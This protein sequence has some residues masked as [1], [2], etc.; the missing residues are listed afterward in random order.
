MK[1]LL[2]FLF[3]LTAFTSSAQVYQND[4]AYGRSIDRY[5]VLKDLGIPTFC[6]TPTVN[7]T[8]TNKAKIAYD[9]C[10][11]KFYVYDPSTETWGQVTGG[12]IVIDPGVDSITYHNNQLCQWV[13]GVSTCYFLNKFYDSTALNHDSTKIL[14]FNSGNL[15]DSVLIPTGTIHI[16]QDGAGETNIVRVE[17]STKL[18]FPTL[19]NTDDITI[20]KASDSAV[21][22]QFTHPHYTK[23]QVDS[24]KA[25][26]T[27]D[28]ITRAELI[29]T[30][31]NKVNK[32][33]VSGGTINQVLKKNSSTDYDWSWQD[34]SGIDTTSLSNRINAKQD[35]LT[36]TTTGT[37]GAATLTGSTL[38]I[39]Q[40]S[41]GGGS[42]IDSITPNLYAGLGY[43]DTKKIQLALDLARSKNQKL[44]IANNYERNSN[45]WMIDSAI[46]LNSNEYIIIRN[47]TLK[48]TD[49]ARDNIFRTANCGLGIT[50]PGLNPVTGITI[51][52]IGDVI[53]QGADNPRASG[54]VGKALTL[55]PNNTYTNSYGT[56]AGKAGRSQYGDWRNYGV[57][58]AYGSNIKISGLKLSNIA[59]YGISFS[60]CNNVYIHD[61]ILDMPGY[62]VGH[63]ERLLYN[64][65]GLDFNQ[66]INNI[67][68]E[69]I[70]GIS[71]DDNIA[72]NIVN[73]TSGTRGAGTIPALYPTGDTVS[74]GS[75]S[76]RNIYVNNVNT[77]T[78]NNIRVLVPSNFTAKN[79][80][81]TNISNTISPADFAYNTW[82]AAQYA[83]NVII[84]LST[85]TYAAVNPLGTISNFN[86]NNLKSDSIRYG[87][88]VN[89]SLSESFI[90]NVIKNSK[91]NSSFVGLW[92]ISDPV[93]LRNVTYIGATAR[94][95][96]V[97]G[98][99]NFRDTTQFSSLVKIGNTATTFSSNRAVVGNDVNAESSFSVSNAT[100]GSNSAST[101][102][103]WGATFLNTTLGEISPANTGSFGAFKKKFLIEP[104]DNFLQGHWLA[105]S[106]PDKTSGIQY[107][108]GGRNDSN[109]VMTLF[110]TGSLGFNTKGTVTDIPSALVH[111]TSE[112]KA[113]LPP[114]MTTAQRNVLSG[115]AGFGGIASVGTRVGGTGYTN[116]TYS[117]TP[118]TTVSGVGTGATANITVSGGTIT[119]IIINL[120]R[121]A[122][123]SG[124]GYK[125][126]DTLSATGLGAGT[127]FYLLVGSIST[128]VA[129]N[130]VYNTTFGSGNTFNGT[131][132]VG[133]F[134]TS[135]DSALTL[136]HGVDYIF[137]GTTSTWTLPAV[138][139][140]LVGRQNAIWI[141]NKGTGT[142]TLQSSTGSVIY[143]TSAQSS[144]TIAAG[145]AVELL[146][147]GTNFNVMFN[148]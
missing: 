105:I 28:G 19:K 68:V 66:S 143:T 125:V 53:L 106:I 69:N 115:G 74:I 34:E 140:T 100:N 144:I 142:I 43:S 132:W 147:D 98:Y 65:G 136:K 48:L 54:D 92:P 11:H 135:S 5:E 112:T 9:S 70:S 12:G 33:D 63:T 58:I 76:I 148:N 84:G 128:A 64:Q 96:D 118:L 86:I 27:A 42:A 89:T 49:S 52:G 93:I 146:P 133:D 36:L 72:F 45:L 38:N 101:I 95:T 50:N 41:G 30:A 17:D 109:N 1:K 126:G 137:T 62:A 77:R 61:I 10:G 13:S 67:T 71:A 6:G 79:F 22:L 139:S 75:D 97:G 88:L 120:A 99:R 31:N 15:V 59:A 127:G 130:Y 111:L 26:I 40:Y 23:D 107:Y 32:T 8:V 39:P 60:R 21:L 91:N 122:Q 78:L 134:I 94:V 56:D 7:S 110:P 16:I 25:T 24:I 131:N 3:I 47:A 14:H 46:L 2:T 51:E 55:T 121:G 57:I 18:H 138:S 113:F 103:V 141:K 104:S 82:S 85:G 124:S 80:S 114:R 20:S 83:S 35:A 90:S 73:D 4:P 116:G 145:A 87:V 37:S 123:G 102:R 117:F 44:I 81:L 129:G 29:D 119:A 108:L